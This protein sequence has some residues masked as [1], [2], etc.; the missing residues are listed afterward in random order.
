[1]SKN[2]IHNSSLD[3]HPFPRSEKVPR[4][5]IKML[6]FMRHNILSR[7]SFTFFTIHKRCVMPSLSRI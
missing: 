4:E 5:H 3:D 1:M 6:K 2:I 7:E